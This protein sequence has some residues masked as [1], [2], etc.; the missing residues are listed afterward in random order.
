MRKNYDFSNAEKSKFYRP[1][2]RYSIRIEVDSNTAKSRFEVFTDGS[3]LYHFRL[4]TALGTVFTSHE[5]NTKE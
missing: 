5:F 4:K 2:G 1:N 3:H